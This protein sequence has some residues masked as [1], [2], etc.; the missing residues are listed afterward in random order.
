MGRCLGVSDPGITGPGTKEERASGQE[1]EGLSLMM[2]G[3][4]GTS[5]L[6]GVAEPVLARR[7]KRSVG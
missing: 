7:A 6:R 1:V 4:A 3:S 2:A 5:K